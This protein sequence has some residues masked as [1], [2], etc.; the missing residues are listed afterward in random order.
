METDTLSQRT[1]CAYLRIISFLALFRLL[2]ERFLILSFYGE[3]SVAWPFAQKKK[4]SKKMNV[5]K[6]N[7][8]G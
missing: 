2:E 4:R 3:N 6:R 1:K 8:A 7:P 5:S